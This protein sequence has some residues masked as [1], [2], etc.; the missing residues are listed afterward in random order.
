MTGFVERPTDWFAF[1]DVVLSCGDSELFSN[2]VLEAMSV[3]RPVVATRVGGMAEMI[4]HERT[5]LLVP[6]GDSRA[7]AHAIDRMLTDPE[8][9]ARLGE[10]ARRETLGRFSAARSFD[11]YVGL[12]RRLAES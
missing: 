10:A 7:L 2:A 11:S 8:L 9:A 5:G 1:C 12:Y 4:E 3:G 6:S